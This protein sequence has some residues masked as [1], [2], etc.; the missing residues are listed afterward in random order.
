MITLVQLAEKIENGLNAVLDNSEIQF[1]IWASAGQM[2]KSL[3]T[4]NTVTHYITGNLLSSSSSNDANL[5]VMGV[6]GL[7]LLFSV[8][9]QAPKTS[10]AQTA[11]QLARVQNSQY[12]F[13]DLILA[14][15]DGYFQSAQAFTLTD[16]ATSTEYTVAMQAGR[17]ITGNVGLAARLGNAVTLSVY[18]TAYFLEGG[19]NSRDVQLYIDGVRMPFQTTTL[20][21][22]N[23]LSSDVYNEKPIVKN[24]STATAFSIDFS[25]PAHSD[26][27][28]KETIA[29]LLHGLLNRAHFVELKFGELDSEQYFCMFDNLTA[30]PTGIAFAGISG[31]L[32]EIADN[33]AMIDVPA[34]MQ[35][36]RFTISD[37]LTGVITFNATGKAYIAGKIRD[38]NGV[39]TITLS[40]SDFT[41]SE[42]DDVYYIYMISLAAMSVTNS[43]ATFTV[44][45]E[46]EPNG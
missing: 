10:S 28:T 39:T 41:Y 22:P 34:Y 38:L 40:P 29:T 16:A 13:I 32:I 24:I 8:P 44:V 20:G 36:G 45:K 33:P 2:S 4:G 35:V 25:Y 43:T 27:T 46:A 19:I 17:A 26:N 31:T 7:T 15:I 14:A 9:L 37:S 23:R 3:R 11:E 6:N 5:L 30:N 18:I 12:P 21:R 1:K 42:S